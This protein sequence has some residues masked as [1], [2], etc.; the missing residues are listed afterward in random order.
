[1]SIEAGVVPRADRRVFAE[2]RAH[3]DIAELRLMRI[4]KTGGL[5]RVR[6]VVR[7][8]ARN[9]ITFAERR[10]AVHRTPCVR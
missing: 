7:H 3:H 4:R 1:M 8:E 2:T 9:G 6:R 10:H 5:D